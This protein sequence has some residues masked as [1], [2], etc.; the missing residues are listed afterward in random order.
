MVSWQRKSGTQWLT[1]DSKG[2]GNTQSAHAI[3]CMQRICSAC[4]SGGV[5]C[6]D[7][8]TPKVTYASM[9]GALAIPASAFSLD[10]L[11]SFFGLSLFARLRVSVR[12]G[13]EGRYVSVLIIVVELSRTI[14]QPHS[15]AAVHPHDHKRHT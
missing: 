15:V 4:S 7:R 1:N 14:T 8:I 12:G 13:R 2:H 11:T 10:A 3:V 9:K 6:R 5:L